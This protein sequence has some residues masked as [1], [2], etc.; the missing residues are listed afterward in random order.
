MTTKTNQRAPLG[1]PEVPLTADLMVLVLLVAALLGAW[2]I[3]GQQLAATTPGGIPGL[4]LVVPAGSL[5]VPSEEGYAATTPSGIAVKARELALAEAPVI[6]APSPTGNVTGTLTLIASSWTLSQATETSLFRVVESQT[7][8]VA[9]QQAIVQEYM[10]VDTD[11]TSLYSNELQ[12]IHGYALIT[13]RDGKPYLV[14]L[15]GPE[16]RF[17]E[18]S[19]F[20]P[21]LLGSLRFR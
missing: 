5:T 12:I 11:N 10:Y 19:A 8:E 14:S 13:V 7:I 17:D 15:D 9:G 3:R 16:E 2:A 18:V 21:R 20:W 4:G 6:G 1:L